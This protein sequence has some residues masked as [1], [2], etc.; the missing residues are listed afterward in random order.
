[1]TLVEVLQS[2]SRW[3]IDEVGYVPALTRRRRLLLAKAETWP[4]FCHLILTYDPWRF[5]EKPERWD[6]MSDEHRCNFYASERYQRATERAFKKAKLK[7]HVG[8]FLRRL[9]R[10]IGHFEAYVAWEFQGNGMLHFHILI[11]R[12]AH[13]VEKFIERVEDKLGYE[14]RTYEDLWRR[15]TAEVTEGN[16]ETCKYVCGYVAKGVNNPAW[17]D[18]YSS[19]TRLSSTTRGFFPPQERRPGGP[20][21]VRPRRAG[22][23]R[24]IREIKR[25]PKRHLRTMLRISIDRIR[26]E[27]GEIVCL[28]R[29]V[30]MDMR[31]YIERVAPQVG[32]AGC[33]DKGMEGRATLHPFG[34]LLLDQLLYCGEERAVKCGDTS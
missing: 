18:W 28:Y 21:G 33:E 15:G 20:P 14:R 27:T 7:R 31:T 23:D 9:R 13:L 22:G 32:L 24:T 2:K 1:V 10:K 26:P 29:H 34:T 3:L 12:P 25:N 5:V 17:L 11:N 30:D 16:L 6:E 19:R 4:V 8:E